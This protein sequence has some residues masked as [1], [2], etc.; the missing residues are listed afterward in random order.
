MQKA[1]CML[2]IKLK[3]KEIQHFL[4]VFI[5]VMFFTKRLNIFYSKSLTLQTKLGQSFL[6]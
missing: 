1:I 2:R 4:L 6:L 5:T 3:F